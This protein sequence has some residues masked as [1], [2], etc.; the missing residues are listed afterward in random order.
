MVE[1]SVQALQTSI[2][3][4]CG[5]SSYWPTWCYNLPYLQEVTGSKGL[6]LLDVANG[7]SLTIWLQLQ[8]SEPASARGEKAQLFRDQL[9]DPANCKSPMDLEKQVRYKRLSTGILASIATKDSRCYKQKGQ[10][11]SWY[12]YKQLTLLGAEGPEVQLTL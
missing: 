9:G 10:R 2:V 6:G 11:C 7:T 3:R 5:S 8:S 4:G 1:V 12:C